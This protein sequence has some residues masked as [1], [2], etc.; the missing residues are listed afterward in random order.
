MASD[1]KL[2]SAVAVRLTAPSHETC[3]ACTRHLLLSVAGA[4]YAALLA[5][6]V[7]CEAAPEGN[8]VPILRS[9]PVKVQD[10]S[11]G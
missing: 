9:R 11:S 10:Q 8:M 4:A 1:G 7:E 5:A 3:G 6:A 2:R